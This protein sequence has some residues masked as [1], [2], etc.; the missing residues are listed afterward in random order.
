[1]G[2]EPCAWSVAGR[3]LLWPGD[4]RSWPQS[5]PILFP[6]VGHL[7]HGR[8][9]IRGEMYAMGVHGFARSKAFTVVERAANRVR[10]TLAH[11]AETMAAYP[12]PFALTV[13]YR[14]TDTTLSAGFTVTN[15][16]AEP[17]PYAL[18]FHPGFLW[19][20]AGGAPEQYALV[21]GEDEAAEV[22]VI[23]ADGL[24]SSQRRSVPLDGKSLPLSRDLMA[25]E[26]LCFL[27]ARSKSVRFVAPD[28][29]AI[30]VATDNFPHIA[31][32]SRPPASF[33]CIESWT[34]YG[35]PEDFDG[36]LSDKPS[37]QFLAPGAHAKHAVHLSFRGDG[38]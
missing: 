37:M 36:D 20:F 14:L 13:D 7:R 6:I 11:D 29:S 19:P 35:D 33:L 3:D 31:L 38:R 2:A 4:P 18:G 12:F 1:M 15:P 26:A 28:G 5:S 9:R 17:L 21:F 23:T 16:S 32:W 27:D 30:D 10:L 25:D 22:P 34:G 8:A 24:F